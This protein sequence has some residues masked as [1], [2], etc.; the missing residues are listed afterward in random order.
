M[1]LPRK[2]LALCETMLPERTPQRGR[3]NAATLKRCIS[4]AYYAV[5]SLLVHAASSMLAGNSAERK[6]LRGYV[7]RA[8]AHNE[9][10]EV[11][12]GFA[13]GNPSKGL[14]PCL[15]SVISTDLKDIAT[16]FRSLQQS[17]HDADYNILQK[18]KKTEAR[19]AIEDAK[20]VFQSWD[21]V[22]G[23]DEAR[24]FLL[25]LLVDERVKKRS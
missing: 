10:A 11:C 17:R 14:K 23:T 25:A 8:F 20:R 22:K 12:K 5:F 21:N 16:T 3:P 24:I 6:E 7:A 2:L 19:Q 13:S 15:P 9:M 1:S 18:P 4:T